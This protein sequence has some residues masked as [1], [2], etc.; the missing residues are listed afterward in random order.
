MASS[1]VVTAQGLL[2]LGVELKFFLLCVLYG[3]LIALLLRLA[4]GRALGAIVSL[5]AVLVVCGIICLAASVGPLWWAYFLVAPIV[6]VVVV[7][8]FP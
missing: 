8:A 5:V 3:A 2:G 4:L 1:E 6:G 7:M